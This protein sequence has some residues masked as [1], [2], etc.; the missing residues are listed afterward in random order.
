MKFYSW[1]KGVYYSWDDEYPRIHRIYCPVALQPLV[2]WIIERL[3][4]VV[5]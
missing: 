4:G 5:V 1:P 2:R 3:G